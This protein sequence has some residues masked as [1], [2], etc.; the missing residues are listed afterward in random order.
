[1]TFKSIRGVF[2]SYEQLLITLENLERK[3]STLLVAVD[4]CGGSGKSTMAIAL[5]KLSSDVTVIH[6]DDFYLPSNQ[7]TSG[8]A[9]ENPVGDDF[10]WLRLKAQVLEQLANNKKSKYQIYNWPS[11]I[12]VEWSI[13]PPGGIVIVEGVYSTRRELADFYDYKIYV[14]CSRE[15]RLERGIQRDGE[16]AR[17]MWENNWMVAEDKYIKEHNPSEH[18]ELVISSSGNT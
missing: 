7:R 4:G 18:A 13:V 10:D 8:T 6:M 17:D 1:M 2:K 3:H 15:F 9:I 16:L 12:L 11:D 14:D 5:A